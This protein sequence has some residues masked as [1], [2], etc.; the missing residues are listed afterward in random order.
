MMA[1]AVRSIGDIHTQA[2]N[3]EL[4]STYSDNLSLTM[5]DIKKFESV[6]PAIPHDFEA[7]LLLLNR[8]TAFTHAILGPNCDLYKKSRN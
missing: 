1:F 8:F 2:T 6:P 7:F 4:L 5:S 3:R